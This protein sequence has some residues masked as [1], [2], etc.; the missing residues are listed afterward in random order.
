LFRF[1]RRR[2]RFFRCHDANNKNTSA[3]KAMQEIEVLLAGPLVK[4]Y[5]AAGK[6]DKVRPP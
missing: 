1:P 6:Y 3:R 2:F 4:P 5:S